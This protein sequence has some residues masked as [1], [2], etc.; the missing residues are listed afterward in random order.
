MKRTFRLSLTAALLAALTVPAALFAGDGKGQ[1]KTDDGERQRH[2]FTYSGHGPG[3]AWQFALGRG[4]LGIVTTWLTPEL[5]A[6]FGAPED[7]GVLVGQVAEDSPAH[8]AGLEVGDVIVS[9]NDQGV[10]SAGDLMVEIRKLDAGEAARLEIVRHGRSQTLTATIEER[11]RAQVDLGEMFHWRLDPN[12]PS[13]KVMLLPKVAHGD[14]MT[15]LKRVPPDTFTN[16]GE[17]LKAIDWAE[18]AERANRSTEDLEERLADL[19]KRLADLQKK[20]EQAT[21]DNR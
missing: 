2:V 5:R 4:Y 13:P 3:H 18:V 16:L 15:S 20:L 1:S 17:S 14:W 8:K 11:E 21:R 10:T 9:I 7:A 6:H 12:D 19:E